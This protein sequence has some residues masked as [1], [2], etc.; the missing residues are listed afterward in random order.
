MTLDSELVYGKMERAL[1]RQQALPPEQR[2]PELA[3]AG[4][5]RTRELELAEAHLKSGAWPRTASATSHPELF[6]VGL[7]GSVRVVC[8]GSLGWGTAALGKLSGLVSL[9][10]GSPGLLCGRRYG[11]LAAA[12]AVPSAA[13]GPAQRI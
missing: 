5:D 8:W 13:S 4:P 12:S 9:G 6:K 2:C 7:S 1:E 11:A 10:F 3:A